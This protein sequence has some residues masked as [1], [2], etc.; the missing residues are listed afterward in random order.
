M[1][2]QLAIILV[3]LFMI[4]GCLKKA[5]EVI[6]PNVV[7]T[8]IPSP[9]PICEPLEENFKL[10]LVGDSITEGT[11]TSSYPSELQKL[12]GEDYEVLN[13]GVSG[14]SAADSAQFPYRSTDVYEKSL[15]Q[16]NVISIVLMFGT[17]DTSVNSWIDRDSFKIAYI[18]LVD[19]YLQSYPDAKLYLCTISQAFYLEGHQEGE[20]EYGIQPDIVVIVNEVIHE[21]ANEYQLPLID[22]FALTNANNPWFFD[23]GIHPNA[24]GNIAIANLVYQTI[25]S[26]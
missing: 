6:V 5:E 24:D 10:L 12:V 8:S 13:F 14:S 19:D 16:E 17:N 9:T 4:S 21:V 18:D 22:V 26:D 1:I 15:Q 2:K 11:F 3:S 7:P 20:A 25:T 23:D